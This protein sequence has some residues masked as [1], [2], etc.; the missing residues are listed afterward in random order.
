MGNNWN[1]D[2]ELERLASFHDQIARLR[3]KVRVL[4][5]KQSDAIGGVSRGSLRDAPDSLSGGNG[6]SKNY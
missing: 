6:T 2:I 5:E 1:P 4:K 3:E